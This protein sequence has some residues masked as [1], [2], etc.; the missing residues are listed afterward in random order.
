MGSSRNNKAGKGKSATSKGLDLPKTIQPTPTSDSSRPTKTPATTRGKPIEGVATAMDT[1]AKTLV[2][3]NASNV[4]TSPRKPLKRPQEDSVIPNVS[5]TKA[6]DQAPAFKPGTLSKIDERPVDKTEPSKAKSEKAK[7]DES[8]E[9]VDGI[10]AAHQSSTN[11]LTLGLNVVGLI[12][13]SAATTASNTASEA[14]KKTTLNTTGVEDKRALL[15]QRAILMDRALQLPIRR[16]LAHL[17]RTWIPRLTVAR[18]KSTSLRNI[19]YT[20]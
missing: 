5:R 11:L 1:V 14:S 20:G 3:S 4:Q 8:S 17:Q 16:L 15:I 19:W 10:G 12:M 9:M 7:D 18:L 2:P 6:S 13:A